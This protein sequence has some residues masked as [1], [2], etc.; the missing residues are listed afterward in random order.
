V[1]RL[2]TVL[3]RLESVL[4]LLEEQLRARRGPDYDAAFF[5]AH[6]A[7]R[8][9][10]TQGEGR[11]VPI[12]EPALFDLADLLGI[13]RA[14]STLVRNTDQ[15][16]RGLP[17]N[18]VLLYGERGTGKSSAVK[19][20]LARFASQ[21]LRVVEVQKDELVHLPHVLAAIRCDRAAKSE[22][23][24]GAH[25]FLIFCDDLSFGQ[26]EAGFR[27]LKAALEGSLDGPPAGV[28]IVA[29]SNRRHLLP[30][31]MADNRG[32]HVDEHGEL[33]L[34]EALDEKLALADRFGLRL[35]FYPFDQDTYL[36]IVRHYAERADLDLEALGWDD[37]RADAL[38]WALERGSRSG[39]VAHQFVDDLAGR[40]ALES[41]PG[42]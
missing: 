20:V 6:V 10:A 14:V 23:G 34:G 36:S 13:D 3:E 41:K 25:R 37:V 29:T 8:W 19:G 31:S 5:E 17:A 2:A 39:R 16:V 15:L 33:H 4:A 40:V 26:G 32:A 22:A 11:L 9:D 24:R 12:E 27:E 35:G 38:R 21:G 1:G 30:E 42:R 28:C 18:N 7:F